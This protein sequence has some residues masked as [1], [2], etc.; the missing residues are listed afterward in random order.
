V[1]DLARAHILGLEVLQER[2]AIYNL[3]CGGDGYTVSEVID[4]ARAVTGREVPLKMGPR[5]AGDPAILIASSNRIQQELKWSPQ[6]QNLEEIVG[7]A[8]DWLQEHPRG[9]DSMRSMSVS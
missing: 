8:W 5:R 9:Y 6:F 7:S 1:V 4:C 2:S 3:G